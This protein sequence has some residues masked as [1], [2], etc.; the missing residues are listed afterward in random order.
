MSVKVF[1]YAKCSTCKDALKFLDENKI[2]YESIAIVEQPPSVA[3][4]K[5]MVK[6]IE[7]RGGTFKKLFNTSGIQYRELGIWPCPRDS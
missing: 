4:L 5:L 3:E 2:K 7:A 6:F 1:E